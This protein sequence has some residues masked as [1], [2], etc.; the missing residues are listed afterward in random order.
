MNPRQSR[1]GCVL[2][3]F[4]FLDCYTLPYYFISDR[5]LFSGICIIMWVMFWCPLCRS[6]CVICIITPRLFVPWGPGIRHHAHT[7]IYYPIESIGTIRVR[8][9]PCFNAVH[10]TQRGTEAIASHTVFLLCTSVGRRSM[11]YQ[12][13]GDVKCEQ[14]GETNFGYINNFFTLV[15][16]VVVDILERATQYSGVPWSGITTGMGRGP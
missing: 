11:L 14:K 12:S 8:W 3:P 16:A 4:Y 15:Y 5:F 13:Y 2:T 7:S 10:L 9:M 6:V 1:S